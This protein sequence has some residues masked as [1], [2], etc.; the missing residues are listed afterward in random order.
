M[1][2]WGQAGH[3]HSYIKGKG[4]AIPLE[5]KALAFIA[6]SRHTCVWGLLAYVCVLTIAVLLLLQKSG[7]LGESLR[8]RSLV[9][10]A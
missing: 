1:G 2:I 9:F 6:F 3:P 4:V 8:K 10:L 7:L 5:N